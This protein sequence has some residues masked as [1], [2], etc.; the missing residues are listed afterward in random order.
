MIR[1]MCAR[2]YGPL[3]Q[4]TKT[5]ADIKKH[6]PTE[7]RDRAKPAIDHYERKVRLYKQR[8]ERIRVQNNQP[9]PNSQPK[10]REFYEEYF[11]E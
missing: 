9:T 1:R 11:D 6:D 2:N 3:S 5:L 7:T 4:R 8:Q 10:Q